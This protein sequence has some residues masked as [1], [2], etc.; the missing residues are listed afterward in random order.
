M[1]EDE[2]EFL[3]DLEEDLQ[4]KVTQKNL[5]L[6]IETAKLLNKRIEELTKNEH[7]TEIED[8]R[9]EFSCEET[10]SEE[11]KKDSS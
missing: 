8:S 5:E 7:P 2:I 6:L 3:R 10:C 4:F 9:E 11:S 1:T